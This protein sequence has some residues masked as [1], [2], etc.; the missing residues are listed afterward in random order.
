MP[1][2]E[3]QITLPGALP[4]G[5]N[6]QPVFRALQTDLSCIQDG[7]FRAEHRRGYGVGCAPR[8]LPYRMQDRY[9][10]TDAPLPLETLVLE[11]EHLKAVFLPGLGGRLYSLYSKTQRRELLFCNPVL[12]IANLA[13]RNA[14]FSGGV[15]W[16]LGHTGHHAFTCAPLY[17][18]PVHSPDGETFLRMYEYEAVH[19][20]ILQ[21]DFHLPDGA[22]QL[23]VHVRIENALSTQAPL[24]WWTNTAAP[25]SPGTRVFSGSK[26]IVYQLAPGPGSL[27]PGFGVCDMPFTPSLPGVDVSY[28]WR[29]PRSTEYFFQNP[30]SVP[31]PWEVSVEPDGR[32]LVERSTQPLCTR[33]MFCWG[34]TA[35]GRHWCDYLAQPGKG[36]YIEIQAGLA[37]TQ[38]HTAVIGA[39]AVVQFTQLFGA[40]SA[41]G[42][43]AEGDWNAALPRV[44]ALVEAALPA[45]RLTRLE[46][47]YAQK[48]TLPGGEL[49]CRGSAY[50]G[51]ERLRRMRAGEAPFAPQL[52]FPLPGAQE[53][54]APWLAFL[55]T[56]KLP[57]TPLPL[58]YMTSPAW[59]NLLQAAAVKPNAGAAVKFQCAVALVENRRESEACKLLNELAAQND[60][61][62]LHALGLLAARANDWPGAAPHFLAAYRQEQGRLDPS[63]AES[64]LEALLKTEQYEAAWQLWQAI[65][66]ALRT[67]TETLAAARA[68]VKLEQFDFLEECF[69][70]EYATIR[71]GAVGLADVWFEYQARLS[72][73]QKGVPFT[74]EAVDPTLPLPRHL[75]FRM[76]V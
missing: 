4:R 23:A 52:A 40:F 48:A 19:E 56:G 12:R 51:L 41:P 11:N 44:E 54:A 9:T 67:E 47:E 25:L 37:P 7:S 15:E 69:T 17:C 43:E 20:Q 75:D 22:E 70:R 1:L 35:G 6:P 36:D 45:A 49:F 31:A 3:S 24:Y 55:Q 72:C 16:N 76:F 38:L 8:V 73:R 46:A 68:A 62:A 2:Y 39:G 65:P 28:P 18:C 71:E 10:R 53:Q 5:E 59:L 21:L 63:F 13:I 66:P 26:E 42:G 61:W 60:P 29:I 14:W 34:S 27:N 74:P 50:G 57:E 30:P 64:A 33:K 32:G 58:P